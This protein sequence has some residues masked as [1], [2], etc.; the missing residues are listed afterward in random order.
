MCIRDSS[1]G[2]RI[3]AAMGLDLEKVKKLAEG[4]HKTLIEA[5]LHD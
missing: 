1:Y 4:D 5:T 3:T 2:E